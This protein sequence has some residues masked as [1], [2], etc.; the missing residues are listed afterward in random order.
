MQVPVQLLVFGLSRAKDIQADAVIIAHNRIYGQSRDARFYIT[1][2][3]IQC[4]P[5]DEPVIIDTS[6]LGWVSSLN[7]SQPIDITKKNGKVTMKQKSAR[8]TFTNDQPRI[9]MPPPEKLDDCATVTFYSQQFAQKARFLMSKEMANRVA[10][11]NNK[12]LTIS[13]CNYFMLVTETN[14]HHAEEME[15]QIPFADTLVSFLHYFKNEEATIMVNDKGLQVN[16]SKFSLYLPRER[17]AISLEM[18]M[19]LFRHRKFVCKV[20]K[21]DLI[22]IIDL[23]NATEPNNKMI[24][25]TLNINKDYIEAQ[26]EKTH[27][28]ID[29]ETLV[30]E[31]Q[32]FKVN[33]KI[34][35]TLLNNMRTQDIILGCNDHKLFLA[36]EAESIK[37]VITVG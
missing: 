13:V 22:S 18:L 25:A 31:Q 36:E 8:V 33:T 26:K 24:F 15:I 4:D 20:K 2:E 27:A 9:L 23:I 21:N 30:K 14:A 10:C 5:T 11:V 19:S 29:C 28:I 35:R 6:Y 16:H 1:D 7:F 3:A 17:Q 32:S 37:A 12:L 34:L